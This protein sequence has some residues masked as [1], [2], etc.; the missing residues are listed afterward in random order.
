[1][2]LATSPLFLIPPE[3]TSRSLVADSLLSQTAI[4]RSQGQLDGDAHII[5]D[6]LGGSAG[7]AS[8]PIKDYDIGSGPHHAAGDSRRVMDGSYLH[9][10]RLGVVGCLFQG[11]DKLGQVLNRV[12]IVLWR[13]R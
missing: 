3:M 7:S 4:D 6:D 10:Y 2:A 13:R 9:R 8:Q 12:D 11:V 1:M 5:A